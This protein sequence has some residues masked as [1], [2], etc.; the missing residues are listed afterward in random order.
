MLALLLACALAPDTGIPPV[1]D[2]ELRYTVVSDCDAYAA[3]LA[4]PDGLEVLS[5]TWYGERDGVPA[6]SSTSW[7]AWGEQVIAVCE[8]PGEVRFR[9]VAEP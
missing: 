6:S 2:C 1:C 5:A 8:G 9:L 7:V 3:D 4:V